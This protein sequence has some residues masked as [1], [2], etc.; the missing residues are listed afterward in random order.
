MRNGTRDVA[1]FLFRG[2]QSFSLFEDEFD[3]RFMMMMMG[4]GCFSSFSFLDD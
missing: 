2:S 3:W 4:E 1:P